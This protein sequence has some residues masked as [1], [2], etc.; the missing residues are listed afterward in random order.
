MVLTLLLFVVLVL[1]LSV[2]AFPLSYRELDRFMVEN[3]DGFMILRAYVGDPQPG[4]G[5]PGGCVSNPIV[6]HRTPT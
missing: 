4:Y 3:G 1:L 6:D 5:S 2:K